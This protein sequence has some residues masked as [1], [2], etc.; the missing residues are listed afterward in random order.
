MSSGRAR[1]AALLLWLA[2]L[3]IPSA[4][5]RAQ[6]SGR[7]YSETGHTLNVTF[8]LFYDTRGGPEILGYPITEA[9]VDPFSGLLVQ[10]M[11]NARLELAPDLQSEELQVRVANLGVLIGG[12]D[13]PL[14][15]SRFPIG[16]S[17]GCRFYER[18]GHQVCHA[19][20]DFYEGHGGP[21]VF[22]FPISEFR[23]E[24]ARVVQYFHDFRLD[25]Y[26]EAEDGRPIRIASLGRAH[27]DRMGYSPGLLAAVDPADQG[28]Y[29]ILELRP[30]ASVLNPLLGV[31]ETQRAYL[32][33]SDQNNRPVAGAAALLTVYLPDGLQFKMMPLTDRNGVAQLE[34]RLDSQP[35]GTRISLEYTVVYEGQFALTRDSFYIWW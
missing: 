4:A 29:S 7:Y 28:L 23:I 31:G 22:G 34:L 8:E 16:H 3:A 21:L 24:Q 25:W 13:L 15:A 35:P 1:G 9:F 26:P 12:W 27:F 32:I 20:L 2:A 30:S 18:S 14:S 11:E 33:V 17:P 5:G 10:Y 19:F 6:P